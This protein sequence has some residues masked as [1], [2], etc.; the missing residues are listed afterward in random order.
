MTGARTCT[1]DSLGQLFCDGCV[2]DVVVWLHNVVSIEYD[3]DDDSDDDD[4]SDDDDGIAY[5]EQ[6]HGERRESWLGARL[7][8]K[9]LFCQSSPSSTS[10]SPTTSRS[11]QAAST[12]QGHSQKCVSRV[13]VLAVVDPS[14]IVPQLPKK[15]RKCL[16][17]SSS[18]TAVSTSQH[19][20][21][22]MTGVQC[23]YSPWLVGGRDGRAANRT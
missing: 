13:S 23:Y 10:P 12:K 21:L 11:T 19:Q 17:T 20:L 9:N 5:L 16:S 18:G 6:Y 7:G 22:Y 4:N 3:D 15:P 1:T 8:C 2:D 14:S